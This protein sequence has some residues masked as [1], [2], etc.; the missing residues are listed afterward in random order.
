MSEATP[1]E[2]A[3]GW[4]RIA[5]YCLIALSGLDV[6]EWGLRN[7]FAQGLDTFPVRM[8][9]LA[10]DYAMVPTFAA[11]AV[12]AH[13]IYVAAQ[14]YQDRAHPEAPIRPHWAVWSNFVPLANLISPFIQI[15]RIYAVAQAAGN[16]QAKW[17]WIWW[18][19]WISPFV[20]GIMFIV[21][22]TWFP[23]QDLIENGFTFRI[24]VILLIAIGADILAAVLFLR[25]I[26]D[27][28]LP[29]L[30]DSEVFG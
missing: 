17:L 21:Y 4:A 15:C 3:A 26:N 14:C 19:A 7:F 5:T 20:L 16:P 8:F 24:E 25:L 2:R 12:N 29:R 6:F 27:I 23:S 28:T 30:R 9:Y 10:H 13:W 11:F 1:L 18:L 22:L